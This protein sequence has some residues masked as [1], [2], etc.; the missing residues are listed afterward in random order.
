MINC[1]WHFRFLKLA[2]EVASWSK[3]PST[4]VGT[5]IVDDKRRPISFGY[6][7]FPRGIA[8]TSELLQDREQKY[9]RVLHAEQNAILFSSK[10]DLS[11]CTIYTTHFPCSQCTASLIQLNVGQVI[12]IQHP[13][14]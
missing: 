7:G 6:N 8:D 11:D 14:F 2:Q 4:Q 10:K 1:T 9:K 3:D 13:D 12:S 5:V